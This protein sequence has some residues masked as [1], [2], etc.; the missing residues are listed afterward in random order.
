LFSLS[1]LKPQNKNMK[2]YLSLFVLY[3]LLACA[4][5]FTGSMTQV[6]IELQSK[7]TPEQKTQMWADYAF[8]MS[9]SAAGH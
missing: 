1:Q 2:E 6:T 8:A 9:H 4:G 7:M 5:S 3:L